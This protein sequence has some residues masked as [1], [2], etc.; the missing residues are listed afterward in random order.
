MSTS[1]RTTHSKLT[2]AAKPATKWGRIGVAI[3]VF[4]R[5][6]SIAS[7]ALFGDAQTAL[8]N[9]LKIYERIP[10][11]GST[12]FQN[13][14]FLASGAALLF[15]AGVTLLERYYWAAPVAAKARGGRA[16]QQTPP[17][18]SAFGDI[19]SATGAV[20]LCFVGAVLLYAPAPHAEAAGNPASSHPES[21]AAPSPVAPA[22]EMVLGKQVAT[23]E[24]LSKSHIAD[25]TVFLSRFAEQ[26]WSSGGT[27]NVIKGKTF[28]DCVLAGPAII[29]PD[30]SVPGA[31][32]RCRFSVPVSGNRFDREAMFVELEPGEELN[33]VVVMRECYL[34]GCDL[35][36]V[37]LAGTA[38]KI[39]RWKETGFIW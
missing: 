8:E 1:R 10:V 14:L 26:A 29:F 35:E 13:I 27:V 6:V 24:E 2:A 31:I 12:G 36:Y 39:A 28:T 17:H 9:A 32:Q 34:I 3:A 25:R 37:S 22:T 33:G 5:V 30:H 38:D 16:K 18:T 20:A 11:L 15:G 7:G 23:A 21:A 19:A 4:D